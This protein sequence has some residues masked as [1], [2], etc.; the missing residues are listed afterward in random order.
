MKMNVQV[1]GIGKRTTVKDKK[2]NEY[3][4]V[5]VAVAY[6]D[7][8]I[9]GYRADTINVRPDKLTADL[10]VGEK[11]AMEMYRYKGRLHIKSIG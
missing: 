1:L 10:T 7:E 6:K 2:G 11:I 8:S 9:V 4:F 3:E 5:P